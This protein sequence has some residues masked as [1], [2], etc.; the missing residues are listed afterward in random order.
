MQL[1]RER[2]A[3]RRRNWNGR[4]KPSLRALARRLPRA[5]WVC[6]LIAVLNATAWSIITPPFQGR[7]EVDH[8]AYVAHLAETG[9][10]PIAGP[11]V[12]PTEEHYV[13]L[14]L[15]YSEVRFTPFEPSIETN[16]QQEVVAALANRGASLSDS[17]YAGGAGSAPPLFYAIQ[18]IPY[19]LG[20]GDILTKLQLMR[21]LDVLFGGITT[22]L[23]FLFLREVL[24][25]VPWAAS[26]GAICVA[27][28]PEFAFVTGSL[29]PDALIYV[30]SAASFLMLARAFR[31]GLS[32]W[33]AVG[34]GA[35][36]AAGLL[37]YFSF[38]GVAFGVVIGLMILAVRNARAG[39]L[40]RAALRTPAI[41]IGIGVS[42][43]VIYGLVNLADGHPLLGAASSVR[44]TVGHGSLFDEISYIWQLFLPRLPG[45]T[46]YF[47]G[48]STWREIWF[49]RSV[50]LYGWMD[51][52]FPTWV[53][54]VALIAA[55]VTAA[56][57]VRELLASR[58]EVRARLPELAAYAAIVLGVLLTIG[59]GSYGSDVIEREIAYGEP[60][61]LLPL[62]PLFGAGLVLA[63]RGAGRRW[64]PV[65]GAA[66][67]VLFLGHDLFSQ[68][69][70]I[71][72][73]YR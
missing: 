59:V 33:L 3:R 1:Q 62:L 71:A 42:P 30:L 21:L 11:Y 56:F 63:L 5:A 41:A 34:L 69:Q 29:N 73:Y 35:V 52:M 8:F 2:S 67:I 19:A 26:V 47:L 32:T 25:S 31:R 14:A 65:A 20:G 57:C 72:R 12:Y 24:P 7:D 61:Y 10:Q 9:K 38:I 39:G 16:T 66:M 46:H 68:L 13:M 27:L 44:H 48:I 64:L 40:G 23:V 28:Q 54:N 49:D 4:P 58:H 70:V 43:A 22:L 17:P 37:T 51:T 6:I 15:H 45:M 53:E 55:L 50:G 36:T 60:R 18:E